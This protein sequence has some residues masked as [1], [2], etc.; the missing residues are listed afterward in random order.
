MPAP[1]TAYTSSGMRMRAS[2]STAPD[3][4]TTQTAHRG[5]AP[6]PSAIVPA[7]VQL[8]TRNPAAAPALTRVIAMAAAA[9]PAAP[10][11]MPR[12]PATSHTMAAAATL[13]AGAGAALVRAAAAPR[14]L[15][16]Q[17]PICEVPRRVARGGLPL[18]EAA[19]PPPAGAPSATTSRRRAGFSA[20][21]SIR[22]AA[23]QLR[24]GGR[25]NRE[26]RH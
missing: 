12:S 7:L 15:Q 25:A 19:R 9:A 16:R 11:M 2:K 14:H 24:R 26:L 21:A 1:T 13:R 3:R 10:E 4:H 20:R 23:G 5:G 22:S 8:T 18:P 17:A 6:Y